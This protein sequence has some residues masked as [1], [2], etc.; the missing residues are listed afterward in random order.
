[1]KVHRI[2]EQIEA[3]QS[4]TAWQR[5]QS[6]SPDHR[7]LWGLG[8][9]VIGVIVLYFLRLRFAQWP[10]H[11]MIFLVAG[12]WTMEQFSHSFLLGWLIK[13]IVVRLGGIRSYRKTK[14]LMIGV[15]AGDLLGGLLFMAVGGLYYWIVGAFP[16]EYHIFPN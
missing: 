15:I 5:V 16:P 10:L 8:A 9:G 4:L 2:S 11:P 14:P 6:I 7:F 3:S 12:T 13:I 1:M